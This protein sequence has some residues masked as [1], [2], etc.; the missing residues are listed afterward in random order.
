M[1]Q[2]ETLDEFFKL[3]FAELS[4]NHFLENDKQNFRVH[5][6]YLWITYL[7]N[8]KGSTLIFFFYH[9]KEIYKYDKKTLIYF[10]HGFF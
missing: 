10:F 3:L 6:I 5:I 7:T 2:K 8:L 9:L 4:D 1:S